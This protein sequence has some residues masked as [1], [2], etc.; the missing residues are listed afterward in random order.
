MHER[1]GIESARL[2]FAKATAAL[3]DAAIA[4]ADAQS[5][6]D[7]AAARHSCD[8]LIAHLEASLRRLHRLRRSLG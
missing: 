7:L 5:I 8:R 4:A 1:A 2:A 3:E 6:S